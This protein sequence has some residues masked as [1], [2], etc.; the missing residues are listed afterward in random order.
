MIDT[1]GRFGL[2][3][4]KRKSGFVL[5]CNKSITINGND[6]EKFKKHNCVARIQELKCVNKR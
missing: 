5:I 4:I 3:F 1:I 6:I 2:I